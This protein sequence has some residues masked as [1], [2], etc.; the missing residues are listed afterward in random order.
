MLKFLGFC[1]LGTCFDLPPLPFD[2]TLGASC[3][4]AAIKT[5]LAYLTDVS[6]HESSQSADSSLLVSASTTSGAYSE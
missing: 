1:S 4:A 6:L 2:F 5:P 3:L